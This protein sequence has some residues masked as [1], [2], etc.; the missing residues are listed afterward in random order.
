MDQ[1]QDRALIFIARP[2]AEQF[3]AKLGFDRTG[4]ITGGRAA[5]RCKTFDIYYQSRLKGAREV[6]RCLAFH[7]GQFATCHLWACDLVW[8]DR[9][10]E[11]SPPPDWA[12]YSRWKASLGEHRSVYEV[13]GHVYDPG[14]HRLLAETIEHAI[15][16]GWDTLIASKPARSV[17]HLSHDDRITVYARSQP[18]MLFEE[19]AKLGLPARRRTWEPRA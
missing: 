6:A 4:P 5:A 16:M 17:Y 12:Q 19:L 14:E 2:N 9:S 3:F 7:Q 15:Y 1:G 11:A 18:S 8:G 10:Q 13:P